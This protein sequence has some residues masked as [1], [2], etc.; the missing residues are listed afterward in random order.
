MTHW[1]ADYV[2]GTNISTPWR[3]RLKTRVDL[4]DQTAQF[5]IFKVISMIIEV[6]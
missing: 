1:P 4:G 3:I 2:R 5:Y 6:F